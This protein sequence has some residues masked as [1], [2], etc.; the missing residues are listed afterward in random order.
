M[1]KEK[2]EAFLADLHVGVLS[3]ASPGG[4]APLSAPVWYRYEAGGDVV[5]STGADSAKHRALAAAGRASFC[6][7]REDLPYAFV[8]VEGSVTI[9]GHDEEERA[10]LAHRY[11]G[12]ELAA[13]YLVATKD[14]KTVTVRLTPDRWRTQDY[15]QVEFD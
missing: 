9:D 8:T 1:G 11:L 6:V 13:S 5:V 3:V 15:S 7:Q 4:G 14:E 12:A 2:R 10:R